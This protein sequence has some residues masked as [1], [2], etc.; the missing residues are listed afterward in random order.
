MKRCPFNNAECNDECSL[1]ISKDELNELVVNRLKAIGVFSD[2]N[3]GICSLK[4]SALA[5]SRYIFENTSVYN[6][7]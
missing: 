6:K 1:F 5:Q 4:S 2:E 7:K 3:G